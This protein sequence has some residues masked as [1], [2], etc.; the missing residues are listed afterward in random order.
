MHQKLSQKI[1]RFQQN[2]NDLKK[3]DIFL[4]GVGLD[5]NNEETIIATS[6]IDDPKTMLSRLAQLC[7]DDHSFYTLFKLAIDI[8]DRVSKEESSND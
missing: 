4:V 6:S 5:E 8:T 1:A 3:L 7:A 2:V